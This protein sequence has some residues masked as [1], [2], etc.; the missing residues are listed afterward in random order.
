MGQTNESPQFDYQTNPLVASE[1]APGGVSPELD[2]V[3]DR[4]WNK[5]EQTDAIE[6][7]PEVANLRYQIL[8]VKTAYNHE[9][10]LIL[11]SSEKIAGLAK[12]RSGV[13]KR[14]RQAKKEAI[15]ANGLIPELAENLHETN[16]RL[17]MRWAYFTEQPELDSLSQQLQRAY[18]RLCQARS[19][20]IDS[21]EAVRISYLYLAEAFRQTASSISEPA[22]Q[23]FLADF[24]NRLIQ[25]LVNLQ[26]FVIHNC[27][28]TDAISGVVEHLEAELAGLSQIVGNQK[29]ESK[30]Y[31]P[32]GLFLQALRVVDKKLARGLAE[33][34]DTQ[35]TY[36]WVQAEFNLEIAAIQA[37][38]E[39]S[40]LELEAQR[41]R[42]QLRELKR[43]IGEC[44]EQVANQDYLLRCLDKD[45]L[46]LAEALTVGQPAIV[47]LQATL[48][49]LGCRLQ[50]ERP[51]AAR[52]LGLPEPSQLQIG[53]NEFQQAWS[54]IP[55]AEQQALKRGYPKK[56]C[57]LL[58]ASAA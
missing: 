44:H 46:Q 35:I 43:R 47:E 49:D 8:C 10:E 50:A 22:K 4:L 54:A 51:A 21:D 16:R 1:A 48:N 24:Q 33:T 25:Q 18:N 30:I 53:E 37:D 7:E 23:Y 39:V 56:I 14:R 6:N 12:R 29:L 9:S 15:D 20:V 27:P 32:S 42:Q 52:R 31:R 5:L 38:S 45:S 11:A 3:S 57:D 26:G 40:T 19:Q 58:Q 2:V 34:F 28:E 41:L 17:F 36:D 55:Q 13:L